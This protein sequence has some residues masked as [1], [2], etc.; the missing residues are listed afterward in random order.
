MENNS[1]SSGGVGGSADEGREEGDN[2]AINR[3]ESEQKRGKKIEGSSGQ[4]ESKL[5]DDNYAINDGSSTA[6]DEG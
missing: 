1:Y 6:N 4:M 2:N 5:D 3:S